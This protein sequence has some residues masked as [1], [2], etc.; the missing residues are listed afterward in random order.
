LC[1][2][3][4]PRSTNV[5]TRWPMYLCIFVLCSGKTII[6]N[7]WVRISYKYQVWKLNIYVFSLIINW[8]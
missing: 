5:T 4:S 2:A 6:S 3:C 1:Y 7:P 8:F